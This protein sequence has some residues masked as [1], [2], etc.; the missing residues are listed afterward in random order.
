MSCVQCRTGKSKDFANVWWIGTNKRLDKLSRRSTVSSPDTGLLQPY[1]HF[2]LGRSGPSPRSPMVQIV[3]N[4]RGDGPTY[5]LS[6]K[7]AGSRLAAV[8]L[9]PGHREMGWLIHPTDRSYAGRSANQPAIHLSQVALRLN[10]N[11]RE[12]GTERCMRW[13]SHAWCI[14]CWLETWECE[15]K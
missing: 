8:P 10:W 11:K 7:E 6:W 3:R 9:R 15:A 13:P 2:G 12:T 5:I 14:A 4:R 1:Q